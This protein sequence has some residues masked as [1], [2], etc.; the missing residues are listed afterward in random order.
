MDIL[1]ITF[2]VGLFFIVGALVSML[3][4]NKKKLVSFSLGISFIVM[5]I[6]ISIDI[7]PECLKLFSICKFFAIGGGILIGIGILMLIFSLLPYDENKGGYRCDYLIYIGVMTSFAVIIHNLVEG[8]ELG[9][10][11][12]TGLKVGLVYV[13]SLG[14]Y[15]LLFG[16]KVS[17]ML[18]SDKK[19][20]WIYISLLTFSTFVGGLL[21]F[22]LEDALSDFL[23]GSLL[24]ISI[25]MI[26]FVII[27]ELFT[28]FKENFNK[29][30][31]IGVFTGFV[32]MIIG[33]GI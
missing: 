19:K 8:I 9:L 27:F 1:I 28:E 2:G 3:V 16:I 29:Y 31:V 33:M 24:S 12:Q 23:L 17:A 5:I 6:L 7:L 13:L 21:V 25:G 4:K 15:N 10:V 26:I 32:L 20:M 18:E 11:I 30:A 14:L 22:I